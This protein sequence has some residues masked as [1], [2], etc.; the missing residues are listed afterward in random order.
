MKD[1]QALKTGGRYDRYARFYDV[2]ETVFENILFKRF[3]GE[4]IGVLTGK[5]LEIG[6][7]TGKNLQYYEGKADVTAIDIS[8]GM[9]SYA[10]KKAV[11]LDLNVEFHLMDAQE[12][13]FEDETFDYV[14][15]SFVLCS[16]PDP[17]KA[18]REFQ[19][20]LKPKGKIVFIEHV[21][22][23]NKLIA[24]LEHLHNPITRYFFGFNV[25]RDTRKN[26]ET[27][28][29]KIESDKHL[30]VKDVFRKFTCKKNAV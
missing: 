30:A 14:V 22:S 17:V 23:K 24:L 8:P 11:K 26:I 12:L 2:I 28:G 18:L 6:V 16:I 25:N 29:W 3:R 27:S 5:V 19:R 10:K 15:G 7:G 1:E 4:T 9:I 21:L 20:V 13:E